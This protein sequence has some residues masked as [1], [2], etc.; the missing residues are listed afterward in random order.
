MKWF[1]RRFCEAS[2][3]RRGRRLPQKKIRPKGLSQRYGHS[4]LMLAASSSLVSKNQRAVSTARQRTRED[5][6]ALKG[7]PR[8]GRS[9]L[10][11]SEGSCQRCQAKILKSLRE[12]PTQ[13]LQKQVET[14]EYLIK[15]NTGGEA[16]LRGSC[17]SRYH[18]ILRHKGRR[19]MHIIGEHF[20]RT[21]LGF[22]NPLQT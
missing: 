17:S 13:V 7:P 9:S 16:Q 3:T 21:T 22:F 10:L 4:S 8:N 5:L 18:A 12:L 15:G 11:L 1:S 14:T 2:P 6:V 20:T 19:R